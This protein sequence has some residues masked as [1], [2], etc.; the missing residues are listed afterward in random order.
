MLSG[1]TDG[2]VNAYDLD[3]PDEDDAIVQVINHGSSIHRA[4]FLADHHFYAL[5][6]DETL[7]VYPLG[8]LDPRPQAPTNPVDFG[9]V[10]SR[11]DCEYVIDVQSTGPDTAIIAAGNGRYEYLEDSLRSRPESPD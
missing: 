7:S 4:G 2:L 11:L 8:D 3:Q 5:S 1:A 6:H 9:D 10:R